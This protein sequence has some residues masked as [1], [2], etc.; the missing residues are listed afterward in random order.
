MRHFDEDLGG[1][2]HFGVGDGI[3]WRG[4]TEMPTTLALG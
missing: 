1:V 4:M 2:G 3:Q